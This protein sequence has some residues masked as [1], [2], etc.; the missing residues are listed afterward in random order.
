MVSTNS[1]SAELG[2]PRFLVAQMGARMHYA[3]PRML[4]RAGMLEHFYSDI[5]AMKGWPRLLANVPD[6]LRPNG[7]RRL[8]GRLPEGIPAHRMTTFSGFGWRYT[9]RCAAAR[10]PA[11][12]TQVHLWAGKRFCELVAGQ[13]WGKASGVYTFNGAGLEV[14]QTARRLGVRTVVEQTIAPREVQ[15]ELL[16]QEEEAFP[17]WVSSSLVDPHAEQFA[18]RQRREWE[19]ADRIVCG[20]EFV[21][22]GIA[23]C[24]GPTDRC[25]VVPYGFDGGTPGPRPERD[26]DRRLRV[27][28]VGGVGLRKGSP[29]V[30]AA[31]KRLRGQA[32][33][34]MV[35]AVGVTAA[36]ESELRRIVQ[37]QGPVPRAEVES[38][39]RWADLFLLP[40]LCEGSATVVYEALAAGIPVICTPHT[41]SV[42]RDGLDGFVVPIRDS[43]AIAD[44]IELLATNRCLW[45][46]M[47]EA[48]RQRAMQ[49]T[50]QHYARRL[51]NAIARP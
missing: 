48:A 40:S 49:F 30:L 14:L 34:R 35:G 13:S 6:V 8:L 17:G 33:F 24:G 26:P 18:A 51:L 29:Y 11:E 12:A 23:S 38:Y 3:V 32:E 36:A 25:H 4:Q 45:E 43:E 47:S 37:L 19:L 42:V 39:Y 5:C 28:T 41:G 31:A 22:G 15:M 7:L 44:R 27:L 16:R 21:L 50:L 1:S 10:S 9:R 2:A 20:S 46:Q